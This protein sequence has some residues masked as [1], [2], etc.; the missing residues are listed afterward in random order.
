MLDIILMLGC[1][2][3]VSMIG[4]SLSDVLVEWLFKR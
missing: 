3:V 1:T 2:V 4:M